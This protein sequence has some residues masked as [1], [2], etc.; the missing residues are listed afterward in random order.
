MLKNYKKWLTSLLTIVSSVSLVNILVMYWL[1]INIP[2]NSFSAVR[3]T[4]IAFIERKYYLIAVSLSVCALLLLTTI[5]IRRQCILL[6]ILS[7]LYSIY[8]FIIVLSSIIDS[9][10]YGY[11]IMYIIPALVSI[12]LIAFLCVYCW[13]YLRYNLHNH[14]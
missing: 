2:L 14:Q 12:A 7:L 10:D 4:V 11:W 13:N 9:L 8:D 3:L 5:A 1:P 6:P